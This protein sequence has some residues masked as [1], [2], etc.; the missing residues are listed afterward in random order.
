MKKRRK[1]NKNKIHQK[2]STSLAIIPGSKPI[3]MTHTVVAQRWANY[4]NHRMV[5]PECYW[6]VHIRE[7]DREAFVV[8]HWEQ[9][10]TLHRGQMP[11]GYLREEDQGIGVQAKERIF[12][13]LIELRGRGI[14]GLWLTHLDLLND[15]QE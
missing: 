8:K 14:H 2:S 10:M 11:R 3:P 7:Q 6:S 15:R 5:E 13:K 1:S 4:E 9:E 12:K